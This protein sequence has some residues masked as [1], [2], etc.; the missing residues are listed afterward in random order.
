MTPSDA[1]SLLSLC[2]IGL[3][4][5]EGRTISQSVCG[6]ATSAGPTHRSVITGIIRKARSGCI[7]PD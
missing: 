5:E 1:G 7:I 6:A 3:A 4:K 2:S